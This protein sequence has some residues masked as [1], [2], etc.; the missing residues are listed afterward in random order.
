[1]RVPVPGTG[2]RKRLASKEPLLGL[3]NAP[4]SLVDK[5][6]RFMRDY[7]EFGLKY[8]NEFFMRGALELLER[9]QNEVFKQ[10]VLAALRDTK[11]GNARLLEE[12]LRFGPKK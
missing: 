12:L 9:L 5:V 11:K 3:G 4:K 7:P 6:E 10:E 1:M 8:R 2:G